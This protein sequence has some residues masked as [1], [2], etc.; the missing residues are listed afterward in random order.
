T[1]QKL[2]P[3]KAI[4]SEPLVYDDFKPYIIWVILILILIAVFVYYFVFRKKPIVD[5]EEPIVQIPPYD[6]A[7]EKLKKLDNKLLWQNNQIKKYYSELTEI[8]R[9]FI[10]KELKIPALEITTQE[11]IE[12]LSNLDKSET[13]QID[14]ETTRKLNSLLS[15][16]DLVKFAKSTPLSH[17]IEDD[18]KN[19]ENILNDLKPLIIEEAENDELE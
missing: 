18:R 3:I 5:Q 8:I 16:A 2:F 13:L 7:I 19:A 9:D 6:E 10:E 11:L 17:E 12:A 1:K 15:E 14:K 4:Q